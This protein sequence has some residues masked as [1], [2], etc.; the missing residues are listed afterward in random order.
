MR[1]RKTPAEKGSDVLPTQ[2]GLPAGFT[3]RDAV[4]VRAP[5]P[6]NEEIAGIYLLLIHRVC[7]WI[8]NFRANPG[9]TKISKEF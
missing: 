9:A 2:T 6:D 7:N 8:R 4:N 3:R 1:E 5:H